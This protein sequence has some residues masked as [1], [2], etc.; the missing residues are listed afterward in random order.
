MAATK[1]TSSKKRV[2]T[3]KPSSPVQGTGTTMTP[4]MIALL[5]WTFTLLSILFFALAVIN[6]A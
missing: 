4:E 6:Y 1:K 3:K 5:V 2:A